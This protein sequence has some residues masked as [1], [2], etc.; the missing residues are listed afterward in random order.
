VCTDKT[1]CGKQ[2]RK[3]LPEFIVLKDLIAHVVLELKSFNFISVTEVLKM[4]RFISCTQ[5]NLLT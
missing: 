1:F 2:A 4:K 3:Y 5:M